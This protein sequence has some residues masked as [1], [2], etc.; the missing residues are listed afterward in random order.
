VGSRPHPRAKRSLGQNFLVDENIQ[1]KI[2]SALG[3]G[4][5]D[6]VLEIGPGR[7]ALTR[8]LVGH[9]GRLVLVELDDHLA[10]S[11]ES[12]YGA[13]ED[14]DVVHADILDV[15]LSELVAG[16]G[17]ADETLVIGN[18]PYNITTPILFHLLER[19]RPRDIV[20][21]VQ[22]DVASRIVADVGTKEYGALSIGV[23]TVADVARLFK[24]GRNAFRPVPR[25]DSAMIRVTPIR[26][27]P[28]SE[29]E[30]VTLRRL[31]R[32]AFQW[33]RKQFGKIL[34]E[35]PDLRY[36]AEVAVAAASAAG[37][38]LTDRPETVTPEQ[39]VTL[40]AALP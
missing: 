33:R 36:P 13:R 1:R 25:V 14:V 18:I 37:I 10:A 29:A 28:L 3:A 19:P 16:G 35:H 15:Q 40:S 4:P 9:V 34:R 12:R 31:V 22:D 39:F 20:L 7:G 26:P 2:V 32:A 30:E 11:L 27:A 8:H 24:V 5:A 6:T 21:M 38:S 23:R 17:P